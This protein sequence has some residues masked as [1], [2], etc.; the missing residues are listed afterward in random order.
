M[1]KPFTKQQ[2]CTATTM[3]V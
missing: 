1:K 3:T 2:K